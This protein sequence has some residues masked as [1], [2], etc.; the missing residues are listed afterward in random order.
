MKSFFVLL[1][2]YLSNLFGNHAKKELVMSDI[3]KNLIRDFLKEQ[4]NIESEMGLIPV[5]NEIGQGGNAVVFNAE[6]GSNEIALKVL[7]EDVES[8]STKYKRFLTEFREIVQLAETRAVVP[9]Y[10]Y[11]HFEVDEKHYPFILM[12]KYPNTLKSWIRE[13]EINNYEKLEP[14]LLKLMQIIAVVHERKIVH[15]DLKPENILVDEQDQLV[16]ADF[17]IS[18]FDPIIYERIV[19]TKKGDRMANFAFSA[20]EQFQRVNEPHPTM[21]IFAL[22]QLITWIITGDVARGSRTPLTSYDPSYSIIEPIVIKMLDASP[23]QRPQ[24]IEEVEKMIKD[25]EHET[26]NHKEFNN[27]IRNV[28][29]DIRVFNEF[30]LSSFPGQRGLV[31]TDNVAQIQLILGR[32][33][34]FKNDLQLGWTQGGTGSAISSRFFSINQDTWLMDGMEIQVEKVWAYKNPYAQDRQF[35]LI[36]TKPMPSFEIYPEGNEGWQEAGWFKDRYITRAEYDDGYAIIDGQSVQLDGTEEIRIRNLKT[37]YYFL[38]TE[39]HAILLVENDGEVYDVFQKIIIKHNL[40]E[41]DV[42]RL[43]RLRKHKISSMLN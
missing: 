23:S 5:K 12:K 32:L 36:K 34:E 33:M 43:S 29:N 41:E 30:L 22:G 16:L 40:D 11:G 1:I 4:K 38:A 15:R 25:R 18:W 9:I 17:G 3:E 31:E 27:E 42:Q 2:K 28:T 13:K 19:E 8:N 26:N 39:S 20:P 7:A 6:L 24:S 10:Y 14:V 35:L 37:E 21:D